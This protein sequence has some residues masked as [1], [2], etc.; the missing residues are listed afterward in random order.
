MLSQRRLLLLRL[1]LLLRQQRLQRLLRQ[2][3]LLRH[4][5]LQL[6]LR[7]RLH[8]Q[9]LKRLLLLL[10]L[11]R[12][13]RHLLPLAPQLQA[14]LV[15]ATTRSLRLREWAFLAQSAARATILSLHL[16]EW[17]A[18]AVHVL[19]VAPVAQAAQVVQVALRVPVALRVQVVSQADLVR[20]VLVLLAQVAAHQAALQVEHLVAS[21][22]RAVALVVAVGV[23]LAVEPLVLSV[24]AVPV[25]RARLASQSVRSA[26][27]SNSAA[28]RHHL[29]AL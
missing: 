16:R 24:R 5:L 14:F 28:M 25:A 23:V 8:L 6:R 19:P 22:A 13:Q 26:K 4:Q 12:L 18:Q 7:L 10:Q 11:R 9:H 27:S 3:L 17:V 21:P 2:P 20:P 29:V 1:R 15:R